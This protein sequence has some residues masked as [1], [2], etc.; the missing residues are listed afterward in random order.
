MTPGAVDLGGAVGV[1]FAS[2]LLSTVNYAFNLA[3][4]LP[5]ILTPL[6]YGLFLATIYHH[7]GIDARKVAFPGGCES[8]GAGAHKCGVP[9]GFDR[10]WTRPVP[11]S[12][13]AA[14]AGI[15]ASL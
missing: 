8:V 1:L 4:D 2:D 12:V 7:L 5:L 10:A 15:A 6:I 14:T 9:M 3:G 11:G 13:R